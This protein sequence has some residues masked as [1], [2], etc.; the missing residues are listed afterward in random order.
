MV[1]LS[2]LALAVG[3]RRPSVWTR[4]PY[5]A[6]G[7]DSHISLPEYIHNYYTYIYVIKKIS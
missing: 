1:D 6:R 2:Q 7:M 5:E 4:Y 3:W